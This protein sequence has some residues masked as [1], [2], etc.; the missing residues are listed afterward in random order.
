MTEAEYNAIEGVRRSDLWQIRLSPEKYRYLTE[1]PEKQ[2]PALVF[3]S[4]VHKLLLEP[5]TF[6]REFIV[7]P[8]VDRRTRDGREAWREFLERNAGKTGIMQDEYE[9]AQEMV[10]A[11]LR[12]PIASKLMHGKTEEPFFFTDGVTGEQCKCRVDLLTELDGKPV[13]VDYKTAVLADT[14]V[15]SKKLFQYGYHL[16]AY[17]YTEAVM[18]SMVLPERPRFVFIAQEKDKPY[19]V[20]CI[21]VSEEVMDAGEREFRRLM[22]ILHECKETGYWYGYNGAFDELNSTE[23]PGWV[24]AEE[25]A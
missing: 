4:M 7:A 12:H 10:Q 22:N 23:V 11:V 15:F 14:E 13:V 8:Q 6:S 9:Q 2:T 18:L 17:M 19:S 3:G 21:E 25:E 16:Q 5:K 20:N 24:T 1:H